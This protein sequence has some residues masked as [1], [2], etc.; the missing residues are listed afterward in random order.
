MGV[1]LSQPDTNKH[2]TDG[3]NAKVAYGASEMQG[4]RM[5]M[6][7]AHI[8]NPDFGPDMSLFTVFDGHGGQEVAKYSE[9]HFGEE[10]KNNA[11]FKAG[12]YKKALI[13]THLKI[14]EM[15]FSPEGQKELNTKFRDAGET[16]ESHAGC[17]SNVILIVG[18][19]VYCANAGDARSY[20]YSGNQAIPLS[21]DHKPDNQIE[22]DRIA[23]AGGTIIDG[24]VNGNL[25][26]S[27]AIGD[28]EY[29]RNPALPQTEQL[30][31]SEPDVVVREIKADDQFILIGCDGI[32]E[33]LSGQ[34]NC[35]EVA[36]RLKEDPKQKLSGIVEELL[37]LGLAPDTSTHQGLGCDNMS[38]VLVVF[39]K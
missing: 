32:W 36:K 28:L 35:N 26:L 10:L 31:S 9:A 4:W 21:E 38:A 20:M 8:T 22:K 13:E 16:Q 27:R 2:S 5:N 34:E 24:R 15:L 19:T 37:D 7:D 29:K 12:D 39:K 11:A 23:K 3:G 25:N 1:Y 33:I 6:E 18:K 30:I 14:D 17:T